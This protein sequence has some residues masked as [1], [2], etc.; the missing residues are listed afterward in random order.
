MARGSPASLCALEGSGRRGI[1]LDG[2]GSEGRAP[3]V[4]ALDC[5]GAV[6]GGA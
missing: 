5:D 6:A 4:G 3:E 2:I 1:D